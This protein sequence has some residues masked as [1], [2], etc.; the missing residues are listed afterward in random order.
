MRYVF[1]VELLFLKLHGE[2][3]EGLVTVEKK[4]SFLLKRK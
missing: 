3:R 2:E 4:L 1:F